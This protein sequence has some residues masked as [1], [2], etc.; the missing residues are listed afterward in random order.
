[1]NQPNA[2]GV[3]ALRELGEIQLREACKDEVL[4]AVATCG[5]VNLDESVAAYHEA[6][7]KAEETR[8]EIQGL[9][10]KIT[11]LKEEARTLESQAK[12]LIVQEGEFASVT[13]LDATD[14]LKVLFGLVYEIRQA[15][16]IGRGYV[17]ERFGFSYYQLAFLE[18]FVLP[19]LE[20]RLSPE[21]SSDD[22]WAT[23]VDTQITQRISPNWRDE[24]RG[25]L[26]WKEVF[27]DLKT[28]LSPERLHVL[29]TGV[30]EGEQCDAEQLKSLIV[31]LHEKAKEWPAEYQTQ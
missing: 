7:L 5:L 30:C 16:Y 13:P 6:Q 14:M 28:K 31:G 26:P 11:G 10:T 20:G 21:W 2:E 23:T 4:V 27:A 22:M 18:R 3:K 25:E 9:E 17:E 8:T 24:K 19:A 15:I 12:L 1:M 29:V